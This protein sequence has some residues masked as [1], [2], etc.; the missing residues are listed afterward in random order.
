MLASAIA[1]AQ[2]TLSRLA[3]LSW[4]AAVA[5]IWFLSLREVVVVTGAAVAGS[6]IRAAKAT[7]DHDLAMLVHAVAEFSRDG[8]LAPRLRRVD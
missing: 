4:A 2:A 7:S 6:T 3:P 5:G 8:E 1:V